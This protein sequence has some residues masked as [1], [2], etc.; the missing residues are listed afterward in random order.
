M[1]ELQMKLLTVGLLFVLVDSTAS[2][3]VLAAP[4]RLY[5]LRDESVRYFRYLSYIVSE[6]HSNC[7][8]RSA[9]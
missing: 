6:V 3:Y 5:R 2:F 9:R 7:F 1:S 8:E 4:G